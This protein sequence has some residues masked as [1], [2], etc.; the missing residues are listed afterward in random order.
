MSI[1]LR[2]L[3]VEGK[4]KL[5]YRDSAEERREW[6]VKLEPVWRDV[7]VVDKD[8]KHETLVFDRFVTEKSL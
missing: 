8:I 6:G 1:E 3:K 2:F 4:A 5:Q 7:P